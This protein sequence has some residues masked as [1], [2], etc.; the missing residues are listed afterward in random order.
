M[1][2]DWAGALCMCLRNCFRLRALFANS[3]KPTRT[4][5]T[6]LSG[7]KI[8][9]ILHIYAKKYARK[10]VEIWKKICRNICQTIC[11]IC[12]KICKKMPENM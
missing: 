10:Y 7:R 5:G 8:H 4:P 12:E 1:R 2:S 11:R 9:H 6:D 3:I